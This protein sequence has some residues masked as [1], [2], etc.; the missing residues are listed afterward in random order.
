MDIP[1]TVDFYFNP[2]NIKDNGHVYGYPVDPK[3]PSTATAA[4][5]H[6]GLRWEKETFPNDPT[7]IRAI[8]SCSI[9][10]QSGVE[11]LIHNKFLVTIHHADFIEIVI[12]S[13]SQ[14]GV[15]ENAIIGRPWSPLTIIAN[16]GPTAKRVREQ[17]LEELEK[18]RPITQTYSFSRLQVGHMYTTSN[19]GNLIC[20]AK[21][22]AGLE[23]DE[24]KTST[25]DQVI[26]TRRWSTRCQGLYAFKTL[27]AVTTAEISNFTDIVTEEVAHITG[28]RWHWISED[29][30]CL[31]KAFI[32]LFPE[33]FGPGETQRIEQVIQ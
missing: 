18:E 10:H 25:E 5:K 30:K 21:G 26:F 19:F 7:S 14:D 1:T 15:F 33:K 11:V 9:G 16:D 28:S 24:N 2:D 17:E 6:C 3:K 31:V 13:K 27:T 12:N 20:I 8:R 23:L 29:E 4:R 32:K 22:V